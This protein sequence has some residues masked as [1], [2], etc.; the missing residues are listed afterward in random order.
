[1]N[2]DLGTRQPE[3]KAIMSWLEEIHFTASASLHGVITHTLVGLWT[4]IDD[5]YFFIKF[6]KIRY[7]LNING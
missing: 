4:M 6:L 3:T 5:N 1:M 2:D 7:L